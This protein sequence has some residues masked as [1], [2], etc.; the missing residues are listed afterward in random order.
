MSSVPKTVDLEIHL[1]LPADLAQELRATGLLEEERLESLLR[2]QLAARR[3]DELFAAADRLAAIPGSPPTSAE[4]ESEIAAAR[5][6]RWAA[7][8]GG[9]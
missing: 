8:A 3:V 7:H 4:V 5:K 6:L 2:G 1:T 9:R